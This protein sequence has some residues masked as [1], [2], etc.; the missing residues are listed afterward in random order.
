[1]RINRRALIAATAGAAFSGATLGRV[2]ADGQR[3]PAGLWRSRRSA[4]LLAV[5]KRRCRSFVTYDRALAL[6]EDDPLDDVEDDVLAA[7]VTGEGRLELERWGEVTRF[8]YDPVPDWPT[9]PRYGDDRRW[10]RDAR[11]TVDAFFQLLI[12]HFAFAAER[13]VDWRELRTNCDAALERGGSSRES[14]FRALAGV[15]GA[16]DDGHGSL[17]GGERSVE[18]RTV[19]P[20]AVQVWRAAG[21][22]AL[23]GDHWHGLIADGAE[24]V[25]GRILAEAG[26]SAA[27]DGL[28]WGPLATGAGYVALMRCEGFS[29]DEGGRADVATVEAALERALSELSDAHGVVVDLRFNNGGWDR[30]ALALAG[31][32]ADGA[33]PAFTKHAVRSGAAVEPQAVATVPASGRRYTGPVAVL[34]SDAT[35]SAG[36]VATLALRALPNTR[37]FGWPTYGALS[38]ELAYVLPNGWEGTISNEVYTATDGQVYENRGVPPTQAAAE[39]SSSDFWNAFD[40]P[41]RDAAAWLASSGAG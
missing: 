34:T 31:R 25:R 7:R 24:H 8:T 38:D 22:R 11:L 4:E 27:D 5:G 35:V 6:V 30:V 36:E 2:G 21:G 15:L 28:F 29:S 37:T 14:L 1:L 41:L 10:S 20:R 19:V 3:L 16:L 23:E 9:G 26:R 17:E 32:F 39:L 40:A 13:G 18:S 33:A 12:E